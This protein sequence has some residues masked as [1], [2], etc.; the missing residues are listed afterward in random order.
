MWTRVCAHKCASTCANVYRKTTT[1]AVIS[2][3]IAT[4][5]TMFLTGLELSKDRDPLS[6]EVT[7]TGVLVHTWNSFSF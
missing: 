5:E 6:A 2:Q 3:E 4:F 1:L 7:C